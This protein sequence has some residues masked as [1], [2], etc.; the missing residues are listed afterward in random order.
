LEKTSPP[1][2]FHKLNPEEKLEFVKKWAELTDQEVEFIHDTGSIRFEVVNRM[3]ENAVG[4]MPVPLGVAVN[5]LI[6]GR[7][8]IIPMATEEPSVIAAASNGARMAR[9][10]GGFSTS[11]TQPIMIGQIQLVGI[12][13]PIEARRSILK[14][15]EKI[16]AKANEQDPILLSL[17]R[18]AKNLEVKILDSI[19][20]PMV[21]AELLVDC[22]DAMG[23]NAV[24]TMAEAVSPIIEEVTGGKVFLR[25]IS[26]LA[27]KRL[28]KAKAVVA[29]EI[30]GGVAV[31]DRI[32]NA[33]AFA[34]ADPYRCATHNKGIMNGVTAVVLASGN[35]TRAIEAG[36]HAYAAK[37]GK[38]L[39][40]TTWGKNE[41][42]DLVG[43]IEM[44][45]AVGLVGGATRA[46]PVAR[47]NIKI[48]AVRTANEL[49][50]VIA[51]VGLAQNLAALRALA[52]EGIQRGH[53]ALH[54]RNVA[55]ESGAKG[56]LIDI[57]AKRM[58][59]EK[60]I[61][62]EYAKQLLNELRR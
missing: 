3:I 14:V 10:K 13:A 12:E 61:R 31:V 36:A 27:D 52:D 53:M 37:T 9:V 34:L 20:G 33:Y 57:I 22:G 7:E 29:K 62:L 51:A 4:A 23:A 6:N 17:G 39:P 49:G 1:A 58:V 11:S 55:V 5:F 54:A 19:A 47:V 24:N 50:E 44:P 32:I 15:K 40:L 38:Y 28:V 41:E 30:V 48:L 59:E 21:I 26:N 42:G 16:I 46:H 35:D 18:G 8:Y 60:K 43:T 2:D 25:I 45:M 56:N